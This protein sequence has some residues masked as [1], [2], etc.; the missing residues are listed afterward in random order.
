M[1]FDL[2]GIPLAPVVAEP[3]DL[4][5]IRALGAEVRYLVMD[6]WPDAD[7]W[8]WTLDLLADPEDA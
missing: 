7:G 4:L 8:G 3:G 2:D 5:V 1:L 6:K